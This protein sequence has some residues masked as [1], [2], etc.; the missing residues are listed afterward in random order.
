MRN[1]YKTAVAENLQ[2]RESKK[3]TKSPT[4]ISPRG[5]KAINHENENDL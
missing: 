1:N 5:R 2:A 3:K 4:S